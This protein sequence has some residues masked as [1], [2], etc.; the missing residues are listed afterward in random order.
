MQKQGAHSATMA[1]STHDFVIEPRK[2]IPEPDRFINY[3]GSLSKDLTLSCIDNVKVIPKDEMDTKATAAEPSR[4]EF[5]F[6]DRIELTHPVLLSPIHTFRLD[7]LPSYTRLR[8]RACSGPPIEPAPAH[9]LDL[10]CT[11]PYNDAHFQDI[12]STAP[13]GV[14]VSNLGSA[15]KARV[16]ESTVS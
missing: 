16:G 8:P 7:F 5:S 2:Q 4:S 14:Q 13:V 11:S 1:P 6:N 9:S 10:H 3:Q 15:A 12:T